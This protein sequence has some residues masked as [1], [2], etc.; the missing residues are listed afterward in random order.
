MDDLD[1]LAAAGAG[2]LAEGKDWSA[3]SVRRSVLWRPSGHVAPFLPA[4]DAALSQLLPNLSSH[5]PYE[6]DVPFW[7][8]FASAFWR[9]L[10]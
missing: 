6:G 3:I 10:R 4:F 1:H 9:R 8:A 5:F 2:E 7:I